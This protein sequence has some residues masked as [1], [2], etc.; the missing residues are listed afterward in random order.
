MGEERGAGAG[1]E[2]QAGENVWER[3]AECAKG[4]EEFRVW[5]EEVLRYFDA[6]ESQEGREERLGNG[7]STIESAWVE[8]RGRAG[9]PKGRR[10]NRR[11]RGG[12][13]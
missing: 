5:V 1:G 13:D 12:G 3:V 11:G 10:Q 4:A 6:K 9:K 8:E 2:K 7:P